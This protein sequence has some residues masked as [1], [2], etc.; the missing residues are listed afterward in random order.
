[1]PAIAA[2]LSGSSAKKLA[3][4]RKSGAKPVLVT[5][6]SASEQAL[7]WPSGCWNCVR[8]A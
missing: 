6:M 1:M 7:L 8:K 3:L 4:A 2:K 5:C